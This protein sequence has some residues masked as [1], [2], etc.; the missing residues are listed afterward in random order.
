MASRKHTHYEIAL[1]QYSLIALDT[2]LSGKPHLFDFIPS[3]KTPD[4][5][6]A[7]QW[8]IPFNGNSFST[9]DRYFF[10]V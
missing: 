8:R 3:A 2:F 5:T 10:R 6:T 7:Y 4:K 9:Y 1:S